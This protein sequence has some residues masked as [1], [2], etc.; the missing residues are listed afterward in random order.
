MEVKGYISSILN[1]YGDSIDFKIRDGDNKI[2]K[3]NVLIILVSITL[4][5]ANVPVEY[6]L[7]V[8]NLTILPILYIIFKY[9]NIGVS[10]FTPL[11]VY[12][13]LIL[14]FIVKF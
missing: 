11:L 10:P 3:C 9:H 14:N 4:Y 5:V 13:I 12:L 6:S 7:R 8:V 2:I 1:Y